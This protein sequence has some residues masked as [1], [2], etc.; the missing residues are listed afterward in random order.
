MFEKIDLNRVCPKRVLITGAC[1]FIGKYI[2]M[3]EHKAGSEVTALV[4]KN[5]FKGD[6]DFPNG[7]NV[8]E[9]D[10]TDPGDIENVF[11]SGTFDVVYHLAAQSYPAVSWERPHETYL[12]NVI[13]THNV[14]N[15]SFNNGVEV[16]VSA[17]SS[18]AYG[19]VD[20][21]CVP[22][23][24]EHPFNPVHPYGVSKA[25]T[26]LIGKQFF[27]SYSLNVV[28]ARIFNTTGPMKVGDVCSDFCQRVVSLEREG[29]LVLKVGN[30]H[31]ERALLDVRDTAYALML[32]SRNKACYGKS[33]NISNDS[34]LSIQDIVSILKENSIV[35]FD[36]EIDKSLLRPVDE[37]VIFGDSSKLKSLTGCT[38]KYII[39][40]TVLDMLHFER[41]LCKK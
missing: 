23:S 38:P 20:K 15:A 9:C 2:A 17:C 1:G 18:A 16:V 28:N 39:S 3:M 21:S 25:A 30:L 22:I 24:E 5:N 4:Y 7:I 6:F 34:I 27:N 11:S 41:N 33:L 35:E 19:P 8:L 26:E 12:T 14:L 32:T 29:G 10:I 40:N 36:V 37:V 31:T 13:G